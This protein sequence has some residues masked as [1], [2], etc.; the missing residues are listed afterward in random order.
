MASSKEMMQKL[1]DFLLPMVNQKCFGPACMPT[2]C[3]CFL[4]TFQWL[5]FSCQKCLG[6]G[7][8][9]MAYANM[10]NDNVVKHTRAQVSAPEQLA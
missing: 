3:V 8:F 10:P 5:A 1:P 7:S 9:K 2:S 4:Q 6:E